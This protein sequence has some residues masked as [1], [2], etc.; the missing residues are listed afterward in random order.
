MQNDYFIL[1]FDITNKKSFEYL[2]EIK[3]RLLKC[4]GDIKI[5]IILLGNKSKFYF[6]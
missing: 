4:K 1:C 2:Y 6:F 5:P 3:D